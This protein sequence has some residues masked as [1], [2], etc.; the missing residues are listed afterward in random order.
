MK[1]C[2]TAPIPL[3]GGAAL[4]GPGPLFC[5]PLVAADTAELVA[6]ANTALDLGADL[7]EWRADAFREDNAGSMLSAAVALRSVLPHLP[8]LFTLRSSEE[9]GANKRI[10]QET[11]RACFEALARAGL[12]DLIDVELHNEPE[13]LRS[14]VKTAH[15]SGVRVMLSFHDFGATPGDEALFAEVDAMVQANADVA[16]L[17]CMPQTACDA[18]RLLQLTVAFRE[19]FPSLA[20][21]ITSMG[22]LGAISR[23]AGFLYGSDMAFAAGQQASAPGQIPL[24]QAR[25][26][27]ESLLRAS[28]GEDAR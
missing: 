20:L 3:R 22:E 21:C 14:V 23:V 27:T 15:A 25:M 13:F 4:G 8:I 18:L 19:R 12:V 17:A 7:V 1:P 9:G 10:T 2:I 11:R 28:G 16:K 5:V 26:I 6:Q 24:Q